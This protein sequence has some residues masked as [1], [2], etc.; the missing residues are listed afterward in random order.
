MQTFMIN[1]NNYFKLENNSHYLIV[2][3]IKYN[4][5]ILYIKIKN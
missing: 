1:S 2:I 5:Y 4:Q 3:I